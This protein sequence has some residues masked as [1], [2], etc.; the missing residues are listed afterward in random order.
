MFWFL[1]KTYE[2]RK[3]RCSNGFYRTSKFIKM[4]GVVILVKVDE[5]YIMFSE[6]AI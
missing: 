2:R 1:K 5:M 6:R 4:K 3:W